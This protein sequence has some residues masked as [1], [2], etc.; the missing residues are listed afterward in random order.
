MY[1]LFWCGK[2]KEKGNLEDPDTQVWVITR[3]G[4]KIN[5]MGWAVYW[6][7]LAQGWDRC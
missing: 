6:I 5:Q 7:N 2:F 1:T 3:T 4:F